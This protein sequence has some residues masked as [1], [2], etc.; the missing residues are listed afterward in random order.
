MEMTYEHETKPDLDVQRSVTVLGSTGSVGRNTLDLIARD[1]D[2]FKG[3]G[4]TLR[5]HDWF[6]VTADFSAYWA[7]QR[8]IDDAWKHREDWLRKSAI[9]IAGMGRFS[10]DRSIRNYAERVWQAETME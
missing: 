4:D 5:H 6:V 3:I 8:R 2:R 10:S 9:N 7:I 1:P